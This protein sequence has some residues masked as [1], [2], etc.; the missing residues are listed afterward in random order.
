MVDNFMIPA[1]P[2][3][4]LR[5]PEMEG[6]RSSLLGGIALFLLVY[7][8]TPFVS[9]L[10]LIGILDSASATLFV[11]AGCYLLFL[12]S[13]RLAASLVAVFLILIISFNVASGQYFKFQQYYLTV[14]SFY[15]VKELWSL[16]FA[17]RSSEILLLLAGVIFGLLFLYLITRH[18][19]PVSALAK[20]SVATV[21]FVTSV[22]LQW[23]YAVV[24]Q[25]NRFFVID[26]SPL[27]H[28]IRSVGVLPF[29]TEDAET[30]A[31]YER[32]TVVR[33]MLE[34]LEQQLPNKYS[35]DTLRELLGYGSDYS[36]R[37]SNSRYPLYK[38]PV[39]TRAQR[40]E[41]YNVIVLVLE[42]VRASEMGAYG[43]VESATPFL[44]SLAAKGAFVRNFYA[45][46]NYTVKSEHAIHCSALD[47]MTGSPVAESSD[48]LK[49][50]CLPSLLAN[51]GYTS[52]WFHG[53]GKSFYSRESYLPKL[54]FDKIYDAE[55]LNKD[56]SM[57][58][59]GWGISD[60]H[61]LARAENILAET[62]HPFYAE[63]LTLSNHLPFDYEWGIEFPDYLTRDDTFHARYRR[64]IYYTD[65]AVERFY[66]ALQRG[67]LLDNSILVITG[68][69][70]IWSFADETLAALHQNEQMFRVPL[71]ILKPDIEPVVVAG[72]HSHLDIAPTII[73][74]LGLELEEDFMGQSIFSSNSAKQKR[75]IYSMLDNAVSYRFENRFCIPSEQCASSPQCAAIHEENIPSTVCYDIP[76]HRDVL[77]DGDPIGLSR[78]AASWPDRAL[79]DYSQIAV[80]VGS[81]PAD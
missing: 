8:S 18:A 20:V 37:I 64:G 80:D 45:T 74:Y 68:D 70:G 14:E 33:S 47:R 73:E 81:F 31:S 11:I 50:L 5:W 15:L 44:D 12:V 4:L 29:V 28:F 13:G 54:G 61:M 79:F 32:D 42:S 65:Q 21:L 43:A 7:F 69:H 76:E 2:R 67:G 25:N 27:S 9:Q 34:N 60:T 66:N 48:Q 41:P 10:S 57:Q 3:Q 24:N 35:V 46:S 71:I 56:G 6:K 58:E 49:T 16:L 26:S 59:L 72:N 19:Q 22:F 1:S 53:N 55:E 77:F 23:G 51:Q 52:L 36:D 38:S 17:Y 40:E 62:D 39:S 78:T 63:I 75:V 30:A